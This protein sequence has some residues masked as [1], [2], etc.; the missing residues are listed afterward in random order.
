[1]YLVDTNIFL[2]ILLGQPRAAECVR[3]LETVRDGRAAAVVTDFSVHSVCVILERRGCRLFLSRWLDD[4]SRF[5]GVTYVQASLAEQ[6]QIADLAAREGLDFDDAYQYF[7]ALLL[8]RQIVSFDRH[9]DD[10][11][12][13]RIEPAAVP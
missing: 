4:L 12:V 13:P 8:G 11:S 5:Q 7:F 3:F 9:F 10:R 2:E 6:A 1:M